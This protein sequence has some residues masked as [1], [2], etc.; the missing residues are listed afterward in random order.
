MRRYTDIIKRLPIGRLPT[1]EEL[2]AQQERQQE[3]VHWEWETIEKNKK[4]RGIGWFFLAGIAFIG[5]SIYSIRTDNLLFLFSFLLVISIYVIQHLKGDL[6]MKIKITDQGIWR[7]EYFYAYRE[8]GQFWIIYDPPMKN[9]YIDF[10]SI[11]KPGLV[12][13]LHG[14]NPVRLR[15][16]L[17]LYLKENLE[18][19]YPSLSEVLGDSLKL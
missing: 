8:I 19:E 1:P 11:L 12:I 9:L 4:A 10:G 3:L 18:R 15:E 7:G 17:R 5:L 13:P 2:E 14:V 16:T 6:P